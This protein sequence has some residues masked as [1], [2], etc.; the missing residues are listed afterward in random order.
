MPY[1]TAMH[2]ENEILQQVAQGNER[3]FAELFN[4]FHQPLGLHIFKFT[5]SEQL[6]EEVVQDVFLK[7]WL[8]RKLLLKIENFRVY[9]YVISKNAA[10]NCLKKVAY[11]SA[12]IVDLDLEDDTIAAETSEEDHRYLLIDEAIDQLPP[13]QK[14]VYLLRRHERLSYAEISDRMKI[15]KETVKKYLQIA[16]ESISM[17]IRKKLIISF[18]IASKYFF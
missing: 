11:E 14:L 18:L 15:S 3:A 8:N 12:R 2:R 9:L 5:K 16:T 6:A 10:F 1:L 17:H 13:Q 7:I 4:H